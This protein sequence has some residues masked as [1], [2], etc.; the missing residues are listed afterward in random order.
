M[1]REKCHKKTDIDKWIK[2]LDVEV[3]IMQKTID[4]AAYGP[5]PTYLTNRLYSSVLLDP[6]KIWIKY[7]YIGR[8]IFSNLDSYWPFVGRKNGYFYQVDS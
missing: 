4:F 7:Y 6:S 2:D 3:W 5:D 8:H 1:G